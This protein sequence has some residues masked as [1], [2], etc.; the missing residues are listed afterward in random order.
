MKKLLLILF[1]FSFFLSP[2]PNPSYRRMAQAYKFDNSTMTYLNTFEGTANYVTNPYRKQY[3]QS[4]K[5][6]KRKGDW[7]NMDCFYLDATGN[8]AWALVDIRTPSRSQTINNTYAGRHTLNLGWIGNNSLSLNSNVNWGDGGTWLGSRNNAS[9]GS[10]TCSVTATSTK[11]EISSFDVGFTQGIWINAQ[12]QKAQC[13]NSVSAPANNYIKFIFS[14]NLWYGA[15]RTTSTLNTFYA[16]GVKEIV[17]T[18]ASTAINNVSIGRMGARNT[19]GWVAG[20]YS[21]NIHSAFYAGNGSVNQTN[22]INSINNYWSGTL[23]P[24]VLKN[25][26]ITFEGDSR[27]GSGNAAF[28][29]L[30]ANSLMAVNTMTTL[31]NGWCWGM[32]AEASELVQSMVAQGATEIDPY[33]NSELLKDVALLFGGTNDLAS[34]RTGAQLFA[35]VSTWVA[36][37][38]SAGFPQTVVIGEC[39]RDA[40]F[41]GGADSA[42][43]RV[44]RINYRVL[45]QGVYTIATAITNCYTDGAGNYWIDTQADSKFNNASDLTYYMADMVHLNSTALNILANTYLAPLFLIVDNRKIRKLDLSKPDYEYLEQAA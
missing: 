27:V 8:E 39:D 35:D 12:I 44:Q 43:Y 31:G 32:V 45:M 29:S 30:S 22:I 40:S 34:N 16:N 36:N 33:R 13:L 42:T 25:K 26:R 17:H 4:V 3:D 28:Y 2:A 18:S 23:S 21:V 38:R 1:A 14:N 19:T 24:I 6:L 9:F 15:N 7:D 20:F 5:Y 37:R 10:L 11:H 41:S